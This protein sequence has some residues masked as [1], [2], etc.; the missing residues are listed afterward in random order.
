MTYHRMVVDPGPMRQASCSV[1]PGSFFEPTRCGGG[2]GLPLGREQRR[3]YRTGPIDGGR[4]RDGVDAG[5]TPGGLDV[6]GT[7]PGTGTWAYD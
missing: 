5:A 2:R 6:F 7:P 1:S 3:P 4:G